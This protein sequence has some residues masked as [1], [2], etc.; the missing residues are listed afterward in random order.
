MN[1]HNL[2]A[3]VITLAFIPAIKKPAASQNGQQ[4]PLRQ[5]LNI[6]GA[7]FPTISPDGS[8]V[9]FRTNITGTSQVWRVSTSSGWPDQLTFSP[10][11]G[12]LA[13]VGE[14]RDTSSGADVF[15]HL[16]PA[17]FGVHRGRH[18]RSR[19]SVG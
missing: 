19:D 3:I 11:S 9:A 7:G 6:R 1:R 15:D 16:A 14:A 13:S 2:L 10:D 8:Q 12:T 4:Y 17:Y 18:D 5:Y